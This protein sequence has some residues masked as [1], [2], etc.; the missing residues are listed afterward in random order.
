ME[1]LTFGEL[2]YAQKK[3]LKHGVRMVNAIDNSETFDQEVEKFAYW[4]GKV[5]DLTCGQHLDDLECTR[6]EKVTIIRQGKLLLK[7]ADFFE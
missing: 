2:H 3:A 4:L 6:E 1:K 5:D 7:M